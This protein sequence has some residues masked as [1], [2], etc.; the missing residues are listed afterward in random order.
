MKRSFRRSGS[1]PLRPTTWCCMSDSLTNTVV[2]PASGVVNVQ[3]ICDWT[4][5][6]QETGANPT[7][8][9]IRGSWHAAIGG[10]FTTVDLVTV[11]YAMGLIIQNDLNGTPAGVDPHLNPEGDWLWWKAG[12]LGL[13]VGGNATS[14]GG[15]IAAVFT[16]PVALAAAH[17]SD[18]DTRAMRRLEP[19]DRV[20]LCMRAYAPSESGVRVNMGVFAR[21]LIKQ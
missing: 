3:T 14:G 5:I 6:R 19:G 15:S 18:L 12:F 17:W 11:A 10:S 16:A 1:R 9:R 20:S 4:T 8:M 2:D 13:A 7:L 21:A